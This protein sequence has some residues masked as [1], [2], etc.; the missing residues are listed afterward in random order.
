MVVQESRVVMVVDEDTQ[1]VN[2]LE[3]LLFLIVSVFDAFHR[4]AASENVADRIVHWIV[5]KSS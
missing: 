1:G 5:E 2:I 3:V 4:L